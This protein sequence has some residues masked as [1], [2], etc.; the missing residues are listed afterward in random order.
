MTL[1]GRLRYIGGEVV[2]AQEGSYVVK[3]RGVPHA[4]FNAGPGT[5]RVMEILTPGGEF[6]GYFDEYEEIVSQEM[7]SEE[8]GPSYGTATG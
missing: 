3:P 5:V 1:L 2:L 4:F 8:H 6:E 7:S